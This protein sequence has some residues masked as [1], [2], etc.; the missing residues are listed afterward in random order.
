MFVI[1]KKGDKLKELTFNF[2]L[3]FEQ[4]FLLF[5]RNFSNFLFV[6]FFSRFMLTL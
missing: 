2:T 1:D 4:S 5:R 6:Y 3:W